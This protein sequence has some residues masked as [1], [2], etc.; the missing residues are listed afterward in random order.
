MYEE[1]LATQ[2]SV[3]GVNLDEEAANL[4]QYQQAYKATAQMIRVADTMFQS[5]LGATRDCER[6]VDHAHLHA[7]ASITHAADQRLLSQQIDA[8]EG[9]R[10]RFASGKRVQTPADD[11]IAAVHIMELERALAESEQFDATRTW[12]RIA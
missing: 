9:R 4:L 3:S 5:V 6:L 8:V 10:T 7:K 1:S 11:P 2:E 12:R